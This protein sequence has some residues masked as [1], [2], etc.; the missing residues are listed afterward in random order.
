MISTYKY[1]QGN[2]LNKREG[3]DLEIMVAQGSYHPHNPNFNSKSQEETISNQSNWEKKVSNTLKG[4][5]LWKWVL[6]SCG[7]SKFH[8]LSMRNTIPYPS[9]AQTASMKCE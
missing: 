5:I 3:L 7:S 8:L 1:L 2:H 9:F 4:K 6:D